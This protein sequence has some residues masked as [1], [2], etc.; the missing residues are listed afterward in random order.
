MPSYLLVLHDRAESTEKFARMSADEMQRAI[1]KYAAW[2]SSLAREGKLRGGEKLRDGSGRVI[3]RGPAGV[4]VL[5][6]PFTETKEVI[7]GY[8]VIEA[9]DYDEV[10]E[11]SRSCPHLEHGTIEVREIEPM[12]APAVA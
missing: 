6:G 8:F 2:S 12:P 10:V 3:R 4:S 5:D 9:R 1:E 11:I 7:G